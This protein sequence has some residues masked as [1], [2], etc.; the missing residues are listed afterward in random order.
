M[1]IT[2]K[3]KKYRQTMLNKFDACDPYDGCVQCEHALAAY[4]D[5]QRSR[6]K[7]GGQAQ[8]SK[9]RNKKAA[10]HEPRD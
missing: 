1:A 4:R 10:G 8:V 6:A 2:D 5:Y 9:G 7:K 3:G